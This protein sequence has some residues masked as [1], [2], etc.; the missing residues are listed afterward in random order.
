VRSGRDRGAARAA[1]GRRGPA[2]RHCRG[3]ERVEL[4]QPLIEREQLVAALDHEVLPEL[5]PAE[6]LEHETAEITEP[7]FPRAEEC[8]PFAPEN[9]RM[10]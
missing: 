4:L 3:E 10:G 8:P 7:L 2:R 6:H 5:V 9:A 1:R